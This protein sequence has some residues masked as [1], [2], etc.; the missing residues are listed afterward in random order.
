MAQPQGQLVAAARKHPGAA[1]RQGVAGLP[2]DVGKLAQALRQRT[3]VSLQIS[4]KVVQ[5]GAQLQR[6]GSQLPAV[7]PLAFQLRKNAVGALVPILP[8]IAQISTAGQPQIA[9]IGRGGKGAE[10][11][12]AVAALLAGPQAQRGLLCHIGLD[13]AVIAA[14]ALGHLIAKTVLV[15]RIHHPPGPQG[16]CSIQR[17]GPIHHHTT[18]LPAARAQLQGKARLGRRLFAHQVHAGRGVAQA[19]HQASAPLH[20]FHP[21]VQ[22]QVLT[23]IEMVIKAHA[24]AIEHPVAQGKPPC[25]QLPT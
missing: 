22:G 2:L 19:L 1:Q 25:I 24:H 5:S 14:L 18:L 23:H 13:H 10:G 16:A 9:A 4:A 11:V 20:H 15:L 3:R 12:A 6:I 8:V 21:V 17:P 7:G